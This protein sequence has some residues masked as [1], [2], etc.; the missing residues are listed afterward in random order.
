MKSQGSLTIAKNSLANL[1]RFAISVLAA[2]VLPP[3]LTRRLSHDMYAAWVLILQLSAYAAVFELGLQSAISKFVAQHDATQDHEGTSSVVST[4]IALLGV[5]AV[6][7]LVAVGVLVW[8]VPRLFGQLTPSLVHEVRLGILLIGGATAIALPTTAFASSFQGVQRYN[9]P[10]VIGGG[11]QALSTVAII[12]A[13][14]RHASLVLMGACVAVITLGAGLVQI[15]AWRKYLSHVQVSVSRITRQMTRTILSYC[16]A[17]SVLSFAMLLISGLDV[18]IVGHFEFKQTGF[19]GVAASLTNFVILT[20]GAV[21]NPLLPAASE[22][23]AL[24][25]YT[26]IASLTLRSTRFCALLLLLTG[27][28]L[29]LYGYPILSLWVGSDY[30][31]H[32]ILFVEILT[33]ANMIRLCMLPY[34]A[35]VAGNGLQRYGWI[36]AIGEAAANFGLSIVLAYRFGAVGVAVGTLIGGVVGVGLHLFYTMRYTRNAIPVQ[37]VEL[38]LHGLARPLACA[39]PLFAFLFFCKGNPASYGFLPPVLVVVLTGILIL[40]VGLTDSDR[41]IFGSAIRDSRL[42]RLL[43]A[44][45]Q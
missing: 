38:V 24:D 7:A 44:L 4:S 25:N 45:T 30:A 16:A 19:Y 8:Q 41:K 12:I 34:A 35:V 31:R 27:L 20:A 37:L 40:T 3:I 26:G 17:M 36:S 10:M 43:G 39:V 32:S 9:V 1:M 18:T 14:F 6:C 21:F 15:V 11:S 33:I 23:A 42:N 13:V 5:S 29:L 22:L 2:V 28:L